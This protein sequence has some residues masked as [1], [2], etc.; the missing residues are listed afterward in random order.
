M[1]DHLFEPIP[2]AYRGLYADNHLVDAQQFGHSIASIG[3]IAN[4]ICHQFFFEN[5]THDPRSYHIRFFVGTSR[6]NGLIQ[7]II[8]VMNNGQLPVFAPI[9]LKTGKYFIEKAFDALIAKTLNR[10]S[11]LSKAVDQIHDLASQH[12]EFASQVHQGHMRDKKWLHGI[13]DR[14]ASENRAPLREVPAPIGRTVRLIEIGTKN[15]GVVIDEPAAEVLRSRSDGLVVGDAKQY[16]VKIVGVFKTDGSCRIKLV[17]DDKIVSGKII[18]PALVTPHNVYTQALDKD[19]PL[20]V[21][22]KPT[23]KDA[24]LHKLFISDASINRPGRRLIRIKSKAS[25]R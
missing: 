17:D 14:L 4:S 19:L 21:T 6:K 12:S 15:E 18:D 3:Q 13:I 8:A 11:E 23:F 20:R 22:A 10:Q 2:I 7:E 1:S 9:L 5:V 24:K 25:T 16:Q